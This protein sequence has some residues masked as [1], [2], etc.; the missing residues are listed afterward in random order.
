MPNIFPNLDLSEISDPGERI[1]YDILKRHLP[2]DY[3]VIYHYPTCWYD[4][5]LGLRDNE[6]DF[7]LII[8]NKGLLFIEVKSTKELDNSGPELIR[9]MS[10]GNNELIKDIV[11][12]I[13]K[14]THSTVK[15]ICEK[16]LNISK[17]NFPG[18]YTHLIVFPQGELSKK[19]FRLDN[20]IITKSNINDIFNIITNQLDQAG[21]SVRQK[22]FNKEVESKVVDFFTDK[23]EYIP[24]DSSDIDAD[25]LIIDSLTEQQIRVMRGMLD[26]NNKMSISG[27]AGSGKTI[28]AEFIANHL[29]NNSKKTLL[30]CYNKNLKNWLQ[31]RKGEQAKYDIFTF[32]ELAFSLD[33]SQKIKPIPKNDSDNYWNKYIPNKFLEI[34]NESRVNYDSVVIDEAQDFSEDYWYPIIQLLSDNHDLFI[35]Y[36]ND[37]DV[38][39][40]NQ[41]IPFEDIT[42][43]VLN[44]NLRN[45]KRHNEFNN[46]IIDSS[47]K[48]H[49]SSPIGDYPVIYS[50]NESLVK[51]LDDIKNLVQDL[52]K[53]KGYLKNQIAILSPKSPKNNLST[54]GQLKERLNK[55]FNF[56]DKDIQSWKQNKYIWLSSIKAF[57]GLESDVVILI[58]I[59]SNS[60]TTSLM[61][62]YVGCSRSKHKLFIFP[63]D[64]KSRYMLD[65]LMEKMEIFPEKQN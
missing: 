28:L 31:I 39:N 9:R 22:K 32:H 4:K 26:A 21:N 13:T 6:I 23:T 17:E 65:D 2:D 1:T 49:E 18:V 46:S 59:E 61:E 43:Y 56:T 16:V 37:Q 41:I 44:T 29:A 12:K 8:P 60:E 63:S 20:E 64:D 62:L 15:R 55:F 33:K 42:K 5:H 53:N 34:L 50:F 40:K 19:P 30:L 58:D 3:T 52:T 57:K 36:D 11:S 38:Y 27:P 51:R 47:V 25:S 14:R 24:I 35:F 7:I 45:T 10:N 48:A 54:I